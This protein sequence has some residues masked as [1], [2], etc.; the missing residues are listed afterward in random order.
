MVP[1]Q[2]R[3]EMTRQ[4]IISAGAELFESDG[5]GNTDMSDVVIQ[6]S[7]SRGACY[8]HF[9]TKDVLAEA[10]IAAS[11]MKIAA[12]M[13]PIW[14]SPAPAMHRLIEAT[15]RFLELTEIDQIVRVGY[16]LGQ[17]KGTT[18]KP[19]IRYP[20]D[21]ESLFIEGLKGARKDGHVRADI[22]LVKTAYTIFTALVGCRQVADNFGD[23]P[24]KRFKDV[25]T[26][27]LS[28]IATDDHLPALEKFVNSAARMKLQR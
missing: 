8:Y 25:W 24:V 14:E 6:A 7:V 26:I 22:D 12:V 11:N 2:E 5:Y 17:A 13:G 18:R 4:R 21:T 28:A 27:V 3:A 10:I 9:P 20:E 19:G 23:N 16:R 1:S 15:F